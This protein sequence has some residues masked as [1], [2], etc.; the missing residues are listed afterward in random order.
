[1]HRLYIGSVI[2]E[3]STGSLAAIWLALF[4]EALPPARI[5]RIML[6]SLC[7][8]HVCNEGST[9]EGMVDTILSLHCC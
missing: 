2:R 3:R 8:S 4:W 6:E 5:F 1:M 9:D 7:P